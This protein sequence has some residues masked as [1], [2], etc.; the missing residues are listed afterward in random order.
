MVFERTSAVCFLEEV[1][2]GFLVPETKWIPVCICMRGDGN[3]L[4]VANYC[5]SFQALLSISK[6]PW[7]TYG[8]GR[9]PYMHLVNVGRT[10]DGLALQIRQ[11]RTSPYVACV[12]ALYMIFPAISTVGPAKPQT[13]RN[14]I[15]ISGPGYHINI[16]V[17]L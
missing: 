6:W 16:Q 2:D 9:K 8:N 12:Q 3:V 11:H 5:D 17:I 15:T 13:Y 10:E 14:V 1:P 7:H 4:T